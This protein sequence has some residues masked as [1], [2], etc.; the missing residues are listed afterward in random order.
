MCGNCAEHPQQADVVFSA[1][2]RA[3][4]NKRSVGHLA[5]RR[6]D[7][8]FL[9]GREELLPCP[10]ELAAFNRGQK[11]VV[12]RIAHKTAGSRD[13]IHGFTTLKAPQR[14]KLAIVQPGPTLRSQRTAVFGKCPAF[15]CRKIRSDFA[16][17]RLGE[18]L[19]F[20]LSNA[21]DAAE[22]A[23]VCRVISRHFPERY[24]GG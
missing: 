10:R 17:E 24:V 5:K 4:I 19:Q 18:I 1:E 3:D 23:C 15:I 22:L 8:L 7:F 16:E 6:C 14:F 11:M 9:R 21:G 20:L 2:Q 13:F 12:N